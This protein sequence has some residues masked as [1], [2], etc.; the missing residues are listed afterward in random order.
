MSNVKK[1]VVGFLRIFLG[2]WGVDCFVMFKI[3]KGIKRILITLA[4]GALVSAC[5]LFNFIPGVGSYIAAGSAALIGLIGTI[6]SI[7]FI[8]TGII[9]LMKMP[10]DVERIYDK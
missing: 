2:V 9:Y 10:H 3:W 1:I 8:V 7:Y 5:A 6:R 4:L